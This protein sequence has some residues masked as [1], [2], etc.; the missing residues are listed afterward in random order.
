[1]AEAGQCRVVMM[2]NKEEQRGSRESMTRSPRLT[3]SVKLVTLPADSGHRHPYGL[4]AVCF[5]NL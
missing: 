4:K 5:L 1:M 3:H 2:M